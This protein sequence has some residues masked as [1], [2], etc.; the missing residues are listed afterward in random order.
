MKGSSF[1]V[2][3]G[4][5]ELGRILYPDFDAA[6]GARLKAVKRLLQEAEGLG[7]IH[8][9]K[10]E[11]RRDIMTGRPTV[12]GRI[13]IIPLVS[14]SGFPVPGT[15]DELG[16]AVESMRRELARKAGA[17]AVPGAIRAMVGGHRWGT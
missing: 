13:G 1:Y 3:C 11:G 16:R 8:R 4:N 14:F 2:A 10:V 5:E 7:L 15:E 9:D 6:M 17:A 12:T